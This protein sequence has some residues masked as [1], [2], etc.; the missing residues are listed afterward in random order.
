MNVHETL[1]S[2]IESWLIELEHNITAIG[3]AVS[4]TTGKY[5]PSMVIEGPMTKTR[6]IKEARRRANAMS[7]M[8]NRHHAELSAL[9]EAQNKGEL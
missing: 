1:R 4:V 2:D 3:G 8:V 9:I 7:E 6:A 5:L